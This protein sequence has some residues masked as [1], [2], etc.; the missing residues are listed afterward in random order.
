MSANAP[1]QQA[2]ANAK[3]HTNDIRD[4]V[5]DVG[6]S[7]EAGLDEFNGAAVYARADED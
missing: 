4:P 5:G 7:V 6:A 2:A 3:N 1:I